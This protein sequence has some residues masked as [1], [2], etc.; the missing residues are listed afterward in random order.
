MMSPP[1]PPPRGEP[2]CPPGTKATYG[3]CRTPEGFARPIPAWIEE[4]MREP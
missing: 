3:M 4:L 1:P 2:V